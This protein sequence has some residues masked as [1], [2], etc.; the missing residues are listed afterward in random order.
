MYMIHFEL[1]FLCGIVWGL[2][3]LDLV[4]QLFK[5]YFYI[6]SLVSWLHFFL[7]Q[8]FFICFEIRLFLSHR[9][10]GEFAAFSIF[11]NSLYEIKIIS[12]MGK[13][14]VSVVLAC[15]FCVYV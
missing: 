5:N 8:L 3:L 6:Y 1:I 15:W 11:Y 13:F 9:R 7:S 14:A 4:C 12:K 10:I 2:M